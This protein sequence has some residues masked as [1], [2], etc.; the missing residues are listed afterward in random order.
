MT[1][2]RTIEISNTDDVI[3]SQDINERREVL[4]NELQALKDE[5]VETIN[6][7][8]DE[9]TKA[10]DKI[11]AWVEANGD[12]LHILEELTEEASQADD[13][14]YG[15]TLV[16]DSYFTTYAQELLEDV[17]DLPKDLPSYIAIDWETTA[18][19]IRVDYFSVSFDGV[20]YWVR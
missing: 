5:E 2:T 14:E 3:D 19:N 6:D 17:G 16:R 10:R 13:W 11:A 18:R 4:W 20:T 7:E 12:E 9:D 8:G 15:V 1:M